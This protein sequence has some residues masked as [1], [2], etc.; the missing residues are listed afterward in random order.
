MK[1]LLVFN[2]LFV[3]FVCIPTNTYTAQELPEQELLDIE[4]QRSKPIS[5]PIAQ[6]GRRY[7]WY[8]VDTELASLQRPSASTKSSNKNFSYQEL[9]KLNELAEIVQDANERNH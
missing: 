8:S 2:F 5:I 7:D 1:H 6:A 4:V 9:R 3:F